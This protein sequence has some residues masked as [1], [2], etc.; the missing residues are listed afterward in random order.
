MLPETA[1]VKLM[2]AIA[3]SAGREEA[4]ELMK[5]PLAGETGDRRVA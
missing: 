5:A 4:V 2:W 3:N 1:Y